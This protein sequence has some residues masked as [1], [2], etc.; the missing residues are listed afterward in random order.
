MARGIDISNHQKYINWD[1]VKNSGIDFAFIKA[2]EG[3]HFKDG[4]F[5][6]NWEEAKRVGL[7]R[8][9]YH[10]PRPFENTDPR[11]EADYFYNF[12]NEA[13][14]EDG[15]MLVLDMEVT[16]NSDY[17]DYGSW[18]LYW[19]QI[20]QSYSEFTPLI[21]TAR[22]YIQQLKLTLPELGLYPLWLAQW[23]LNPQAVNLG[24]IPAAPYPWA[25]VP[26]WQYTSKGYT[27][28][29]QG[30]VDLNLFDGPKSQILAY[31]K[32]ATI[33]PP[34]II[35]IEAIETE[36]EKVSNLHTALE[37]ARN[38]MSD[39]LDQADNTLARIRELLRPNS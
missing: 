14:I 27:L 11:E 28:G 25:K 37:M 3:I 13:G 36:L 24:N 19:L 20:I 17:G 8:G 12:V 23:V 38:N 34:P 30:D 7:V 26:F 35:D 4:W 1:S 33:T 9:A 16:N 6:S 15:D 5:E 39:T 2:T 22:N 32:P 29:I 10:F 18:A 21:Y 31:G